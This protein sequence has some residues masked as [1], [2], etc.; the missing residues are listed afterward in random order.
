MP[1]QRSRFVRS[2]EYGRSHVKDRESTPGLLG[3][4]KLLGLVKLGADSRQ[5]YPGP[6][7]QSR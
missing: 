5:L 3:F 2:F 1:H 7:L 6:V 4:L